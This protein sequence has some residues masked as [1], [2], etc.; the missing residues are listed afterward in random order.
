MKIFF[1]IF[2][3]TLAF[4]D[5]ETLYTSITIH[6]RGNKYRHEVVSSWHECKE[7]KRAEKV[8]LHDKN[9]LREIFVW[10]KNGKMRGANPLKTN[11][12]RAEV[13]AIF[14]RSQN[15]ANPCLKAE[16]PVKKTEAKV[17]K[18]IEDKQEKEEVSKFPPGYLQ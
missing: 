3:S 9:E 5:S 18:V 13:D 14:A 6:D 15:K 12:L 17:E 2:F 10:D 8:F 4:A 16:E 1:L 7:Q 11:L